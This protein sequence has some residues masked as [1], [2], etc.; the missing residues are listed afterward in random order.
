M[1]RF[2]IDLDELTGLTKKLS[3]AEGLGQAPEMVREL[4]NIVDQVYETARGRMNAGI[5][6]TDAYLQKHMA[7]Q[8]ASAAKGLTAEI[9]AFGGKSNQTPLGRYFSAQV[10]AP[11][12]GAKG[13]PSKGVPAGQKAAGVSVQVRRGAPRVLPGAFSMPLRSGAEAGGN[14][15]GVFTRSKYGLVRHRYGPAPYQLFRVA[16][17]EIENTVGDTVEERLGSLAQQLLEKALS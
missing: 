6:L 3:G 14:G 11:A 7:V 8:H 17:G 10:T 2:L 15:L 12:P 4:N 1:A 16:A 5:N 9:T 13:N